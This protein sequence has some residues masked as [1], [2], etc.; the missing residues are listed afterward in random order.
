[1]S[2]TEDLT[3]ILA[4]RRPAEGLLQ[5]CRMEAGGGEFYGE[6]AVLERCRAAPIDLAGA[7]AVRGGAQLALFG[8]GIAA[9][10]DV[11][12]ERIGRIWALGSPEPAEPEP[13]VAVAFD[14]DLRQQRGGVTWDAA[15]H[16]HADAAVLQ[17]LAAAGERLLEEAALDGGRPAYRVRAFLIRAWSEGERGAGLF[18]LHRLGS[19]PVRSSGFDYAAVLVDESGERIVRDRAGDA[20]AAHARL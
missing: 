8:D 13:A 7:E 16:P 15:D 20:A 3:S 1:M 11:H 9:V 19:G 6:E 14:P 2:A 12:G 17:R 5:T 4:G 10:A 18:A